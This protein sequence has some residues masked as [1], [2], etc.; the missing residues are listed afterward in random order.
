MRVGDVMTQE[1]F[2]VPPEGAI[3]DAAK[4][5]L[6]ER[7]SGL[8]VINAA[9]KLVGMVT[10]DD[11]LRRAETGTEKNRPHWLEFIVNPGTLAVEYVHSH[12]RK[13]AEVMT[14]D[15]VTATEDTALEQAVELMERRHVKR[16][17]V[18]RGGRVVGIITRANFLHALAASPPNAKTR[19]EDKAIRDQIWAELC[20]RRWNAREGNVVVRDGVVDVWGYIDD[21][22]HRDAIRVAAEN[23]P[24]VKKVRDH[25]IWIEP[26][27]G[28]IL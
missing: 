7:I 8:P 23:V 9:H 6:K 27:V 22:R 1:V 16:L 21:E 24:G 11:L 2:S 12:G 15:V 26:Y 5:M 17:P 10:E 20:K 25:L 28:S 4:I 19:A 3:S 14:S 18:V 13:V